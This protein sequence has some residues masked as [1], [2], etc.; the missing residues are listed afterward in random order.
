MIVLH[1]AIL[2]CQLT[3]Y[4][5]LDLIDFLD[6]LSKLLL[7]YTLILVGLILVV[8]HQL[9][10]VAQVCLQGGPSCL[11]EVLLTGYRLPWASI[12]NLVDLIAKALDSLLGFSIVAVKL[13]VHFLSRKDLSIII[14]LLEYTILIIIITN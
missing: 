9:I 12:G 6:A 1:R 11:H 14:I 2:F 5:F 13:V 4:E 8:V 7:V 3:R 10:K